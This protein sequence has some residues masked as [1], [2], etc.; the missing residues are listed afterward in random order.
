M[1][2]SIRN[3]HDYSGYNESSRNKS[4]TEMLSLAIFHFKLKL[5]TLSLSLLSGRCSESESNINFAISITPADVIA[6]NY[7]LHGSMK[8]AF[9]SY[10]FNF[11]INPRS[12]N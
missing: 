9:L 11:L 10:Y 5:N 8:Q 3:S 6:C 2:S 12:H 1:E 4:D 7:W